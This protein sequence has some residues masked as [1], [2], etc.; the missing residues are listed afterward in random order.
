MCGNFFC[1]RKKTNPGYRF[2]LF[3]NTSLA[4]SK[5]TS[6]LIN[7]IQSLGVEI[8][9]TDLTYKTPDGFY[10]AWRNQ[11]YV[12]DILER[13][14][15]LDMGDLLLLD[16]DCIFVKPVDELF[17]KISTHGALAYDLDYPDTHDINGLTR[18]QLQSV[19]QE[20][21]VTSKEN[22]ARYA[23]GEFIGI[24]AEFRHRMLTTIREGWK[25][26]LERFSLGLRKLNE[27]AHLLSYAYT[28]H[29]IPYA[30]ANP[31]IRRIWT[32]RI[33]RNASKSDL[34]LM[35]WHVPAETKV[36]IPLI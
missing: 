29:N 17:A 3:T 27:E 10:G 36:G 31:F 6:S 25:H 30:S 33:Y 21:G 1:N 35:I 22:L 32:S 9:F 23:G 11:F 5:R 34:D 8:I 7:F 26:N 16:S 15:N 24:S 18:I 12:I 14:E 19:F 20:L 13:A 4:P 2:V 28:V